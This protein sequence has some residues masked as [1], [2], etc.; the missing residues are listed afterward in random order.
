M[1]ERQQSMAEYFTARY[2]GGFPA[3]ESTA[4]LRIR[5]PAAS[6][7]QGNGYHIATRTH[8]CIAL[9]CFAY[10]CIPLLQYYG[11]GITTLWPLCLLWLLLLWFDPTTNWPDVSVALRRQQFP[12]LMLVCWI[13]IILLNIFFG[14]G[15]H[16]QV[17]LYSTVTTFL[18]LIM[19]S[20]YALRQDGSYRILAIAIIIFL[21]F[22]AMRALPYMLQGT[23]LTRA[24]V[25]DPSLIYAA[26]R[27]GLHGYDT[28]T[29]LAIILP[30]MLTWCFT[31]RG[32]WRIVLLVA[33]LSLIFAVILAT[34]TAAFFILLGGL[35]LLAFFSFTAPRHRWIFLGI[36]LG[37]FLLGWFCWTMYL[38]KLEQ[39]QFVVN[40][41]G[42]IIAGVSSA[43]IEA[44][45]QSGRGVR[46]MSSVRTFLEHPFVGIGP[47][48]TVD[49]PFLY[50]HGGPVGGHA[51][52]ADQ[53][54]EYGIF[55]F[56][57]YLAFFLG[58]CMLVIRTHLLKRSL[59]TMARVIAC[60]LFVFTGFVDPV[61]FGG[62]TILVL[63]Y[64]YVFGAT[65]GALMN[66]RVVSAASPKAGALPG[67]PVPTWRGGP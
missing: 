27:L 57:F 60:L 44:G 24:I 1:K 63:F 41:A 30:C 55:G 49:N 4:A 53:L 9:C 12:L 6:A 51:S 16:A 8:L 3:G 28:Y 18:V 67:S 54:A 46:F 37:V 13:A 43:G 47:V 45:D 17:H 33:C 15:V 38:V 2:G 19:A 10:L 5:P 22:D 39:V 61:I 29:G 36:S 14:R 65:S 25:N 62:T 40:K 20:Y 26:A 31:A 59:T 52:W 56:G 64:F 11:R 35:F 66:P 23:N 42:V 32:I 50:V 34:Y 7:R 21:A 58:S 48:T